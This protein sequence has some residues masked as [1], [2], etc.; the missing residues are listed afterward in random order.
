ML[1]FLDW[2]VSI[3]Y[4]ILAKHYDS[5]VKDEHAT[6]S[7]VDFTKA[8]S[9]GKKILELACGSGEISLALAKAGF[10]ILAS[11]NSQAMLDVAYEKDEEHL[12]AYKWMDMTNMDILETFDTILCYC[13]SINYLEYSNLATLF[14][15]V[16]ERLNKQGVFLFDMHTPERLEE[17]AEEFY[18]AGVVDGIEFVWNIQSEDTSLYH[19]FVFYDT[20]GAA[21]YEH[22]VQN[23]F[24]VNKVEQLLEKCGFCVTIYTDFNKKGI[25]KGEKYFFVCRKE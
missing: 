17:F 6:T 20:Q 21:S 2:K 24:E 15:C 23:V 4:D 19:N 9:N 22:H 14:H 8:N 25:Q 16:Y 7:Y 12:V 11:D 1:T 5:L 3:M 13:D 10:T 18:E